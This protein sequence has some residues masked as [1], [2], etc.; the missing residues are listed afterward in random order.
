MREN[1]CVSPRPHRR[2]FVLGFSLGLVPSLVVPGA[3]ARGDETPPGPPSDPIQAETDARLALVLARFGA[4]LDEEA[5]MA[6]RSE[7][8][9]QVRRAEGLRHFALTNGEGPFPVFKPYRSPLA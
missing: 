1:S 9:S 6:I 4:R 7:I 5:R 8:E 2:D 3:Q